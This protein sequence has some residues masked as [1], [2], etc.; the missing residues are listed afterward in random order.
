MNF[1]IECP[2]CKNN[3][4]INYKEVVENPSSF[5]C[6]TCGTTPSP[7]IMTAYQ[8]VGKTMIDLYGCCECADKKDWFPKE[9][10]KS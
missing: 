10:K 3:I 6:C 4:R 5:K 7:D 8:N 2:T 1:T 9:I